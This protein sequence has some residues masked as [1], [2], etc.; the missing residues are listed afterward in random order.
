[1]LLAWTIRYEI[2]FIKTFHSL[3]DLS[4]ST[5]NDN[6][7]REFDQTSNE[8]FNKS[9]FCVSF[10]RLIIATNPMINIVA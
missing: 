9:L 1:M 2:E 8:I 7:M 3:F 4:M 5:H 10:T 6:A